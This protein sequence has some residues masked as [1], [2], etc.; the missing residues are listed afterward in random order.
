MWLEAGKPNAGYIFDTIKHTR[1]QYH[2]AVRRCKNNIINIEKQKLADNISDSKQFWK[3]FKKSPANKIVTTVMDNA[4]RDI[5]ITEVLKH[6]YK[7]LYNSLPR[8]DAE[9]QS[10][11]SIVNNGVNR[12]QLQDIY[13]TSDII[14]QCIKRLKRSKSVGNYGFKP[15]HLI[16]G[17]KR[18]HILLS[19]LF[20]SMLIHGYNAN[21]FVLSSIISIPKDIS[22]SLSSSDNYRGISLFNGICKLFDYVIMHTC[23]GYLYTSDMQFGFKPQ[24]STTMCS[25]V[26]NEIINYYLSNNSNVYSCLLDASKAFDKVHYEKIFHILLNQKVPF[27][28]IR[29]SMDS[30]ERQMARV[31]WN[32]HVS[33]YFSIS[34][35]VKQGGVISPVMF[36]LYFDNL[37]IYLEQ[38]GLG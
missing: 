16:N 10:L 17:G 35:G 18:L 12:D 15:Y 27:C 4:I 8:S 28:I 23:N 11:Y 1:H 38:S 21:D 19:M 37:L 33:E 22:F 26:Y 3:E 30:F 24:H 14:A 5:Q 32:S 2:Y 6:K 31:M 34:N 29:L 7:S 13:V 9:M 20:K 25:L 36:N